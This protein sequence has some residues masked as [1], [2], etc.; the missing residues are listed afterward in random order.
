MHTPTL[1][2]ARLAPRSLGDPSLAPSEIMVFP[3]GTH[4]I[5]ATQ[6][7]RPVTKEIAV[8][9]DTAAAMQ[10]ALL[11][12]LA[13]GPQKP[14]FD[15][16]HD[17]TCASAWPTS[18]RWEPGSSSRESGVYAAVQ[19]TASGAAAVLGRDYRS[20]S[21]AFHID[22]SQPA[23]VTGAPL[24]M[25]GLV[26]SPAFRAQ[27]PIWAKQ[28]TSAATPKTPQS[29]MTEQTTTPAAADVVQARETIHALTTKVQALEARE[30]ERRKSDAAAQVA[31]AVARGALAPRDEAIQAKWRGLIEAD[32]SHASLLAALPS[33]S[34]LTP[35]T[36]PGGHVEARSGLIDVLRVMKDKTSPD[37][38]AA[39]YAKDVAPLF[40][41]NA[42]R[43][44]PILAANSLG[45]L[46]GELI[47]QR[48]LTL[49][50]RSF[51]E[52][53]AFSTDFS[54]TAAS[55]NQT[56][57]ARLRTIPSVTDYDATTGYATSDSTATDVPVV[58]DGHKAV[59]IAFNANEL[60]STT[61]DLFGE[62]T[63][64]AH[65]AIGADLVD[66][67]LAKITSGNFA[68]NTVQAVGGF[69]RGTLTTVAKALSTRYVPKVGR[70]ALLNLDYYEALGKDTAIVSLATYQQAQIITENQ[71]PPVAGLRPF[72]VQ[73]LPTTG[74]LV[75]FAG[76]PD[77]LALSTRLPNDYTQAMPDVPTNGSVQIVRNPD[78]GI[79]VMLVRYV[80]HKLGAAMWR[81]A[82]M[83]GAAKGQSA[84]GQR[85]LSA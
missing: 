37:D 82:Y 30:T 55:F 10:A 71:L 6:G 39:I 69:G 4:T 40:K 33:S 50:K 28:P 21:P 43:L 61:R 3:A 46:S 13:A 77:C 70:F 32:P 38:R 73:N 47:T 15:F 67:V 19:W 63:E 59:Q 42:F 35:I 9:P 17:D 24:N 26:N 1:I 29:K 75:G 74:N 36:S 23:R 57:R 8:G 65:N 54:D 68:N 20:F 76:T 41:D 44:G 14:Y 2:L 81:V 52:L 5:N 84:S 25:G 49:L 56:V 58:I 7:G 34:L 27:S 64:G 22:E 60:G 62:Q 11:A 18:F 48:S 45:T 16:D 79:S 83:R 51:P 12:H 78:T 85:I 80:D 31:A 66:A 72:E 53:F